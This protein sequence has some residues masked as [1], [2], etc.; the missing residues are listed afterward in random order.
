MASVGDEQTN[1]I[2]QGRLLFLERNTTGGARRGDILVFRRVVYLS[3][4][5]SR[6]QIARE[7]MEPG[8]DGHG[9]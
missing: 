7:V 4:Q 6:R 5:I 3:A 1:L 8:S 2:A 9:E